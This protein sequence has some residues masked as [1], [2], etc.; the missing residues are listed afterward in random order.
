MARL[1]PN[2]IAITSTPPVQQGAL[3]SIGQANTAYGHHR[4]CTR[5]YSQQRSYHSGHARSLQH[6]DAKLGRAEL[7]LRWGTTRES[8]VLLFLFG[9]PCRPTQHLRSRPSA[10]YQTKASGSEG[11]QSG[12]RWL[13]RTTM[14]SH[15]TG[16]VHTVA[17]VVLLLP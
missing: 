15:S 13:G 16:R 5:G 11:V 6:S 4:P 1:T 14:C 3:S 17:E 12:A 10:S 9:V 2:L 8:S 7:V